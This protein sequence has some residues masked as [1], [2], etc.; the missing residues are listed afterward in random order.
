MNK[1]MI[2]CRAMTP[3]RLVIESLHQPNIKSDRGSSA[4]G[5]EGG[6][7]GGGGGSEGGGSGGSTKAISWLVEFWGNWGGTGGDLWSA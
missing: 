5:V 4:H 7:G 3:K 6:G 1:K 2:W